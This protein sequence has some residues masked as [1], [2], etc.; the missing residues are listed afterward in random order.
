[1]STAKMTDVRDN[2]S[3]FLDGVEAGE[4]LT[5]TRHGRPIA[6]VIAI[7]EYESMVETL[8]ILSDSASVAAIEEAESDLATGNV[9]NSE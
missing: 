7:D 5:I 8:N 9:E 6:V 2:L 1:M 3:D 4:E